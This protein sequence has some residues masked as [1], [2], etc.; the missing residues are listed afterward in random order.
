M[1][2]ITAT[3]KI[4][5]NRRVFRQVPPRVL[6]SGILFNHSGELIIDG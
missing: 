6:P 5:A 2:R 1:T 4:V 3:S